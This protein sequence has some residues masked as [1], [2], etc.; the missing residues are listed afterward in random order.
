MSNLLRLLGS[1]IGLL[2]FVM[3]AV[4]A[5][6]P[7]DSTPPSVIVYKSG[8]D[9]SL[10]IYRMLPDGRGQQ[11]LTSGKANN[12]VSKVVAGWA[13]DH[14]CFAAHRRSGNFPHAPRRQRPA[15]PDHR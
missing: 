14:L 5:L 8:H 9:G 13:V 15:A 10:Q 6:V 2:S 12:S 11:P 4:L 3:T 1:L 7:G